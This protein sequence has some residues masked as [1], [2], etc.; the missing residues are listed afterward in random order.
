MAG[1]E[2]LSA[3]DERVRGVRALLA[4]PLI[5]ARRFARG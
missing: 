3:D 1:A 4:Q 2:Q 5:T